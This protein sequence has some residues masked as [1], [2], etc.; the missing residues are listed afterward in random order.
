M[1]NA[2]AD[3]AGGVVTDPLGTAADV[4]ATLRFMF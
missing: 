4:R 2:F 3:V 1:P